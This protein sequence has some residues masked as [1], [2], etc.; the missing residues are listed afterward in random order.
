M[1]R[2]PRIAL[3][4]RPLHLIQRCNNR[5]ACFL[6]EVDHRARVGRLEECVQES[7]CA[8]HASVLMTNQ[9]HLIITPRT[10]G[11]AGELL[12]RLGQRY[13]QYVNGTSSAC[14]HND[15]GV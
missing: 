3:P 11:G 7:E 13:V 12:K 4:E 5:Q 10:S 2:Q 15:K 8:I 14:I 6:A 9:V 1:R